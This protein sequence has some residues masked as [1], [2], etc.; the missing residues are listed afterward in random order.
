MLLLPV[1]VKEFYSTYPLVGHD[2][3]KYG[4]GGGVDND[5][6]KLR[7]GSA[8]CEEQKLRALRRLSLPAVSGDGCC[9]AHHWVRRSWTPEG[10][11]LTIAPVP[12]G[13]SGGGGKKEKNYQSYT[14]LGMGRHRLPHEDR[15]ALASSMHD[16]IAAD[17][18]VMIP[19]TVVA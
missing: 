5:W 9:P 18:S 16:E 17:T 3:L 4:G 7:I 14:H 19:S 12:L 10:R 11:P 8:T 2:R 13:G 6:T 15:C 1:L